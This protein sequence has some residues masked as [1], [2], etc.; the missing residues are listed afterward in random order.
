MYYLHFRKN[1][2]L[3]S[4]GQQMN[5]RYDVLVKQLM[6]ERNVNEEQ[7][8]KNQMRW[9]QKMNNIKNSAE[10]TLFDEFINVR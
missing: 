9:V 4:M 5:D 1:D 10:E 6:E 7:K 8:E 2:E 3:L